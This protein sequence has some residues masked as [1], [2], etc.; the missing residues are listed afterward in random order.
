M[1]LAALA[2]PLP[3]AA[4]KALTASGIQI[5]GEQRE[6]FFAEFYPSL[7]RE[8]E[9]VP[10]GPAV[11]L[12]QVGAPS[13]TV[14]LSAQRPHQLR[15]R[16]EWVVEV[17]GGRHGEPLWSPRLLDDQADLLQRVADLVG[18]AYPDCSNPARWVPGSPPS[19]CWA[20]TR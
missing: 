2:R 3:R 13:L 5:P 20:A 19:R 12:P 17:G 14:T 8:L 6:R 11:S 7:V 1:R 16:W 15:L 18:P 9:V 10:A 4:R